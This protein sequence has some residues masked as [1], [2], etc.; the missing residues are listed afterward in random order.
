MTGVEMI[1]AERQRQVEVED[2]DA[3]HDD[4]VNT[5]EQLAYA[6]A[7][8]AIPSVDRV[9]EEG[10]VRVALIRLL[11]PWRNAQFKATP[12]DRMRELAKAGAL[13]AAEIERLQRRAA[14]NVIVRQ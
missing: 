3:D 11:W 14:R 4:L 5:H 13:I 10:A 12:D 8:Y 7:C 2:F 9:V 6:A 1:A